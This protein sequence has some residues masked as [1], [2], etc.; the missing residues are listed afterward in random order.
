MIL[1]CSQRYDCISLDFKL[2]RKTA[3][4]THNSPNRK[5]GLTFR[6]SLARAILSWAPQESQAFEE[7]PARFPYGSPVAYAETANSSGGL[8]SLGWLQ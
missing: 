8:N 4:G 3:H 7:E 2:R 6:P 1:K 5:C